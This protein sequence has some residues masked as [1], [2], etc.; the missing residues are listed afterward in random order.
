MTLHCVNNTQ[1]CTKNTLRTATVS[2]TSKIPKNSKD[3][4]LNCTGF[5]PVE[6]SVA[7]IGTRGMRDQGYHR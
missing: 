5:V 6:D 7:V 2:C 1:T 3:I 4:F